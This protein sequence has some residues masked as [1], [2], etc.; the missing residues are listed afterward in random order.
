MMTIVCCC[1]VSPLVKVSLCT[2]LLRFSGGN[3]A[4]RTSTLRGGLRL[5]F[6]GI[7]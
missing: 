1:G 3:V 4:R 5:L 6:F 7:E 2:I